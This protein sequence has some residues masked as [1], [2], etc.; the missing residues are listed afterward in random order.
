MLLLLLFLGISMN[1]ISQDLSPERKLYY[2][3]N[4]EKKIFEL[5]Y[6]PEYIRLNLIPEI[7]IKRHE[8]APHYPKREN[9]ERNSEV[10]HQAYISWIELYPEEY[11]A[12][13]NYLEIY[14]RNH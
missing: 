6:D 2:L 5:P 8:L 13:L 4:T 11:D 7:H 10:I 12:Y 9:L 14:I 3:E 1:G